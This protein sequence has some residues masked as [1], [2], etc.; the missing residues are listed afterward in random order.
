VQVAQELLQVMGFRQFVPRGRRL[1]RLRAHHLDHVPGTGAEHPGRSANM[2]V[3]REYPG[4][5]AST[6][7]SW[8][9]SSTAPANPSTPIS[10]SRCPAP[11]KAG[12][13]PP[14]IFV[15]G[16]KAKQCHAFDPARPDRFS[17]L[18][19]PARH[20]H[21]D[22]VVVQMPMISPATDAGAP[23]GM[24]SAMIASRK[25]AFGLVTWMP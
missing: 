23:C 4:V 6:S 12:G 8:A 7:R 9:A 10:A 14:K 17:C 21:E 18:W 13:R 11:A 5:E 2:P 16:K 19:C 20:S 25:I 24:P 22:E 1:S 15:D 3:W